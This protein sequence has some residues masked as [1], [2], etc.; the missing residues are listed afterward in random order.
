MA[1]R[2]P[3]HSVTRMTL[4]SILGFDQNSNKVADSK[5]TCKKLRE[6]ECGLNF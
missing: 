4:R 2:D 1:S 5:N 6:W 3:A